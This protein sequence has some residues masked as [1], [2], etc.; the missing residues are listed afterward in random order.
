MSPNLVAYFI[1]RSLAA[2]E[3]TAF[4]VLGS[5]CIGDIY[6]PEERGTALSWFLLATVVAPAIGPFIGGVIVTYRTWRILFWLQAALGALAM[7][8]MVFFLPETIKYKLKDDLGG[9]SVSEKVT[10]L[11]NW[12]NPVRVVKL[13]RYPN[14]LVAVSPR[15]PR[16]KSLKSVECSSLPV[17]CLIFSH[18]ESTVSSHPNS[19]YHQPEV[20][21][22]IASTFGTLLPSSGRWLS[23]RN[24]Y[25]RTLGRYH[26][27][28]S[29]TA[30]R[31][32]YFRRQT[33][34]HT[35]LYRPYISC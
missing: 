16:F 1:F 25:R 35:C 14:L 4:Y 23:G 6:R 9:Y 12:L 29:D 27:E 17:S 11:C 10:R 28:K 21:P 30:P 24:S 15:L 18:L 3:T 31:Q 20:Q 19:L 22:Y 13:L 5:S 32:A 7:G 8:L 26:G 33:A 2:F 34:K